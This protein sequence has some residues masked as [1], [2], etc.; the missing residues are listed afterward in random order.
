MNFRTR[1]IRPEQIRELILVLLIVVVVIF[2][3]SQIEGY[4][5]PRTFNR[6]ATSVAILVVWRW[7]KRWW[8]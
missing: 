7:G 8:C 1:A 5:S 3:G 2:F 6:I 4:Y